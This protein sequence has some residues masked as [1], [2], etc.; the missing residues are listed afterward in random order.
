M[1]ECNRT[2]RKIPSHS[3]IPTQDSWNRK[4]PLQLSN[5]K[6]YFPNKKVEQT[7]HYH[8]GFQ[9]RKDPFNLLNDNYYYK[10]LFI[11]YDYTHLHVSVP[12]G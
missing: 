7:S 4:Q 3:M 2:S 9:E 12:K 6:P 5:V 10:H 1:N 8:Q 11:L